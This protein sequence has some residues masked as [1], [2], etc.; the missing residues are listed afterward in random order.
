MGSAIQKIKE[1]VSWVGN[2]YNRCIRWFKKFMHSVNRN[3]E[4][5]LSDNIEEIQNCEEPQKVGQYLATKHEANQIQKIADKFGENLSEA[6]LAAANNI[7]SNNSF[8]CS[9]I[10]LNSDYNDSFSEK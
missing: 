7:L 9:N 2:V 8:E 4:V 3:T 6:D 5:F 10:S 1:C